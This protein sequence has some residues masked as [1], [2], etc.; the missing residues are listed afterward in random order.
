MILQLT[1]LVRP[2]PRYA[3][4]HK[5]ESTHIV[6]G[7]KKLRSFFADSSRFLCPTTFSPFSFLIVSENGRRK[8]RRERERG[9]RKLT[10][11]SE[12]RPL[13]RAQRDFFRGGTRLPRHSFTLH[14]FVFIAK[15]REWRDQELPASRIRGPRSACTATMGGV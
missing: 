9:E 15:C 8:A 11:K 7:K 12:S 14:S 4:G 6:P 13:L 1:F 5:K 10:G 2:C 3:M